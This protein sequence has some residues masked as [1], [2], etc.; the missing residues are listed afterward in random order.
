MHPELV[1]VLRNDRWCEVRVL[2]QLGKKVFTRRS[3]SSRLLQAS[4]K[5]C[6]RKLLQP[7][8]ELDGGVRRV[9]PG[10]LDNDPAKGFQLAANFCAGLVFGIGQDLGGDLTR[11]RFG[12]RSPVEGFA[13]AAL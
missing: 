8:R 9:P 5:D 11:D 1:S 12:N 13:A 2:R 4:I 3:A 6:E 7:Q 10:N